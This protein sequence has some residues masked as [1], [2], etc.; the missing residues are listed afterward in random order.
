M[1]LNLIAWIQNENNSSSDLILKNGDFIVVEN[2]DVRFDVSRRIFE[3]ENKGKKIYSANELKIL[4][5]N[6]TYLLKIQTLN[7]DENQRT[8]P[9]FILVENYGKD[10]HSEL[11]DLIN[12]TLKNS[13]Y[14]IDENYKNQILNTL[15]NDLEN[16][17]K[18]K[19]IKIIGLS[20]LIIAIIIIIRQ[21]VN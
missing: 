16:I 8:L 21:I 6:S 11:N 4:C 17:L 12:K 3:I 18:K 13:G 7:K 5:L 2:K 14:N 19:V 15:K 1:T 20:I 9:M 10:T